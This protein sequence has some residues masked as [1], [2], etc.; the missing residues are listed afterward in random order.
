MKNKEGNKGELVIYQT[1]MWDPQS[2]SEW[3]YS[4]FS[5]KYQWSDETTNPLEGILGFTVYI[6]A[7]RKRPTND[8]L[9]NII[10]SADR[11][12]GLLLF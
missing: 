9:G 12:N 3:P 11:V 4:V 8:P 5:P 10:Q 2:S 6:L 7:V 1:C